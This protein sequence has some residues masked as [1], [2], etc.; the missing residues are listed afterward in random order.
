MKRPLVWVALPYVAGMLLA[1]FISL[2]LF[3]LLALS[4]ALVLL[5]VFW[6]RARLY[7]LIPLV[8]LAGTA[9]SILRTTIISPH[10]LRNI[11][12]DG[13]ELVTIRGAL[14]ETPSLRLYDQEGKVTWRT[15]A[16]LDVTALRLKHR[17]W[18]PADGRIAVTTP[19]TLTNF[20][21]GQTFEVSGIASKPRIAVAE[22]TFDYREYLRQQEIYYQLHAPSEEDWKI[23]SAPSAPPLT[24]RFRTWGRRALAVGLP[25]E[26]ESLRLEWALALGWK[27]A[28]TDEVSEPFVRAATYH[29][30]AVDGLRMAII[31][32]IFFSILRTFGLPRARCGLAILPLIWFYTG[33]T[34]WPASAIRASI[35]LTVVVL[36][37]ALKRPS[38]L[39]NSL[40][41]AALIILIWQPQQLF[42]AGFQLS[43]VVVLFIILIVPDLHR[44]GMGV[45]ASDPLLPAQLRRKWH[46][47]VVVPLRFAWD[48]LATSFAAWIGSL[49]L[50]A[51]YF[52]IVTP[53]STPAN[54]IAVPLCAL[55][56]M[57]NLGSFLLAGWFP[58]AAALFN[59]A[60]W[61]L[62]ECIRVSSHW[63]ANWP[64]AYFY[65]GLPSLL[66]TAPYYLILLSVFTGW[67]FK[68]K[69]RSAKIIA[70]ALLLSVWG[71]RSWR[72]HSATRLTILPLNGGSAAFFDASGIKNDLL[73]DCGTTNAVQFI[74]KPFLR[75]QDRSAG[76]PRLLTCFPWTRYVSVPFASDR[77]FIGKS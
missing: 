65:V 5:A 24:D 54:L 29:I 76:R 52:H 12:R 58:A 17:N 74:T 59:H 66:T 71:A 46:P 60:G 6:A 2:P 10:D 70:L 48:T 73:V 51:Y 21:S 11:L 14:I 25:A 40:F 45:T 13:P 55:V 27:T 64:K 56:L 26:D 75:A 20:F 41:T 23:L 67:F 39:I 38:D 49:P 22:G 15:M 47:A 18:Q 57:S 33:L 4:L 3:P 43:F 69:L 7:L 30:F 61:F 77:L 44:W 8:L 68:P 42:Q 72:E 32:G 9:N 31:F 63:F 53:V 34:G 19:G 35:M 28:L 50:A 16:R 62:M 36:G 1:Q 37:W